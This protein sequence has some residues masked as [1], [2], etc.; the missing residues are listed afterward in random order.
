MS[1]NIDRPGTSGMV[2]DIHCGG[3][4]GCDRT[5]ELSSSSSSFVVVAVSLLL[6]VPRDDDSMGGAGWG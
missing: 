4:I 3:S 2:G 6:L 5:A 1:A